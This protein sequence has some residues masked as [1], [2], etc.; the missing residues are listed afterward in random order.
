MIW[1]C[2]KALCFFNY[3]SIRFLL[4]NIVVNLQLISKSRIYELCCR[5]RERTICTKF[6][7]CVDWALNCLRVK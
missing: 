7:D 2:N 5:K 4:D 6:C 1:L 3:L